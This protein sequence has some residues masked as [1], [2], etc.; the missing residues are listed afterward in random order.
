[1]TFSFQALLFYIPRYLWKTWE[2]GKVKMLVQDMNVPIVDGDTKKD[3]LKLLV[4]YFSVNRNNHEFYAIKFFFCEF[5]NF[6]NVVGQIYFMDFFL[7]GEFTQ[8]GS[9][10]IAMTEMADE[11]RTDPMSRVFPKVTKCTFHK[12]GP[13]GTVEK[14][15]GL[16]V[17]PLN[18]INEKIYVFLWFWFIIMS[19]V[20]G[21]QVVYRLITMFAGRLREILLKARARLAPIHEI[22]SI[23]RQ[24]RLGD[25]FLLYQ[26]GKN[27]DPL[28]FKEFVHELYKKY[29]E[30][31]GG[32]SL[33]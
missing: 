6:V 24:S 20:T 16:C 12:F 8:Y 33:T 10:V 11:D 5:L 17:L 18:I 28:I 23:C 1:M 19:V 9:D 25:W 7:G 27:I 21:V 3:R 22:E 2:G 29:K 26:L 32:S 15:D 4:D 31:D 30:R 13:S 14:F